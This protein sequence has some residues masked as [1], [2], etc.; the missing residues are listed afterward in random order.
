MARLLGLSAATVY[1]K[2]KRYDVSFETCAR[3]P[4]RFKP[5]FAGLFI[6]IIGGASTTWIWQMG[7]L[8]TILCSLTRVSFPLVYVTGLGMLF[9]LGYRHERIAR[10]EHIASLRGWDLLIPR[11]RS[12]VLAAASAELVNYFVLLTK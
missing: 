1:R 9:Y 11:W 7:H 8:E 4:P 10:G 6:S 2:L 5:Q 3:N 12:I